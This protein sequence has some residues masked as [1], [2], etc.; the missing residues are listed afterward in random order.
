MISSQPVP[1]GVIIWTQL[2][3]FEAMAD[4][5][6]NT[7]SMTPVSRRSN[8]VAFAHGDFRLTIGVHS[9]IE[10]RTNDP[11]RIMINLAVPDIEAAFRRLMDLGVPII[12]A[13]ELESWGGRIATFPDPDGNT[14]QLLQL[15][16]RE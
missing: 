5:Y 16:N 15:P 10:G 13:P 2:N 9:E 8:H 12:R 7:L 3:H 11:L 14:V 6:Q 4:F 1:A